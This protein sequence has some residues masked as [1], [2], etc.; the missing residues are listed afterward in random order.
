MPHPNTHPRKTYPALPSDV[1]AG[2]LVAMI[3]ERFSPG[4]RIVF[5]RVKGRPQDND[6]REVMTSEMESLSPEG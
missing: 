4:D 3:E 6:G 2:Q 5:F 1:T